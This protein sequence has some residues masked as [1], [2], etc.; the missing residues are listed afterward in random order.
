[1]KRRTKKRNNSKPLPAIRVLALAEPLSLDCDP[2]NI[3]AELERVLETSR[4]T[5]TLF[6][7]HPHMIRIYTPDKKLL[8]FPELG[9]HRDKITARVMIEDFLEKY[10]GRAVIVVSE[11]WLQP[12]K[13]TL[14]KDPR[15]KQA[16]IAAARTRHEH[17]LAVQIF[18]QENDHFS[19]EAL[20]IIH[21][22]ENSSAKDTWLRHLEFKE[23][24]GEDIEPAE[25]F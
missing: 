10:S 4:Q 13:S 6:G 7:E 2:Q 1:M 18:H 14:K 15:P 5:L 3:R 22:D 12:I 9:N 24:F 20:E 16:L 21:L 19:F 8:L 11:G 25:N 23:S 17:L